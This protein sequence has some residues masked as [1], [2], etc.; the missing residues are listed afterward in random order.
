MDF[1]DAWPVVFWL[2]KGVN[3][4]FL[5]MVNL[6]VGFLSFLSLTKLK[7]QVK[8]PFVLIVSLVLGG[9]GQGEDTERGGKN[10]FGVFPTP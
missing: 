1:Y 10:G 3:L 9:R 5:F 4:V 7:V 8:M 6:H 2:L